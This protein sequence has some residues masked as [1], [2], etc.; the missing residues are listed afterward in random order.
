MASLFFSLGNRRPMW[1]LVIL[2]LPPAFG[3]PGAPDSSQVCA[4]ADGV[5]EVGARVVLP[6][7]R[8]SCFFILL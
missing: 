3:L 6:P 4:G 2:R 7:S 1:P 5:E 8:I